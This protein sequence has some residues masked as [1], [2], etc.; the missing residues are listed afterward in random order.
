[1]HATLAGLS[2]QHRRATY[3]PSITPAVAVAGAPSV[4]LLARCSNLAPAVRRRWNSEQ[5][6]R[7]RELVTQNHGT[8]EQDKTCLAQ[9][10]SSAVQ[11]LGHNRLHSCCRD[12]SWL[13]RLGSNSR[14]P[15]VQYGQY[16]NTTPLPVWLRHSV[17]R[18]SDNIDSAILATLSSSSS[19]SSGA[20]STQVCVPTRHLP[21]LVF[22]LSA[23]SIVAPAV[24]LSLEPV[25]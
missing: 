8:L 1:M 17:N 21:Q 19:S 23:Q 22:S 11:I 6:H 10:C 18:L 2:F 3:T 25:A 4:P 16:G 24:F 13:Q 5:C 12:V 15:F 14:V 7:S 20:L 9:V